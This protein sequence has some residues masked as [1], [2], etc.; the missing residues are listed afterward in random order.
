MLFIGLLFWMYVA[1]ILF[2]AIRD[3][4]QKGPSDFEFRFYGKP[5]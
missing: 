5:N 1:I 2:T 3:L 4:F